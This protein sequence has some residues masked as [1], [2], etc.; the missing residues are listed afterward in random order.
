M[1][2]QVPSERSWLGQAS[3]KRR[4]LSVLNV[5]GCAVFHN[6]FNILER[7]VT[8]PGLRGTFAKMLIDQAVMAPGMVEF[9][10]S[11]LRERSCCS[12]CHCFLLCHD[13]GGEIPL[14]L[15]PIVIA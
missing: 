12:F 1:L 5:I 13:A 6:W 8:V 11:L 4:H 15:A 3:C 2:L 7:V 9:V 10:F 14:A